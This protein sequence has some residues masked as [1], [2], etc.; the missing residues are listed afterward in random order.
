MVGNI[1]LRPL[2]VYIGTKRDFEL[3]VSRNTK[4][5]EDSRG[6]YKTHL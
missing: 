5:A 4:E 2:R 3:E 1:W 6:T